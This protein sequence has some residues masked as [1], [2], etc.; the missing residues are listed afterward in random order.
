MEGGGR[1]STT[2]KAGLNCEMS[3][4]G[5]VCVCVCVFVCVCVCVH[6]YMHT[7]ILPNSH[8]LSRLCVCIHTYILI[9]ILTF[10]LSLSLLSS[11]CVYIYVPR[12]PAGNTDKDTQEERDKGGDV[13]SGAN[14]DEAGAAPLL[15]N[16]SLT[17][18]PGS[19]IAIVG[20]RRCGKTAV[21]EVRILK[22][23]LYSDFYIL[24]VLLRLLLRICVSLFNG[25]MTRIVV[26]CS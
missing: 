2:L 4:F 12:Y 20:A 26:P 1:F 3:L 18:A 10:S 13:K 19:M 25:S 22:S 11:L 23:S 5:N 14:V 16:L 15:H 8:S 21:E 24:N 17:I 6:A 7:H 9:Y